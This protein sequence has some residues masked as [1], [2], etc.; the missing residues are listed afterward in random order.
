MKPRKLD[1]TLLSALAFVTV[2]T[3]CRNGDRYRIRSTQTESKTVEL[4]AAKSVQTELKMG[5]GDLKISG[6]SASLMNATFQYN[7]PGMEAGS[8]LRGRGHG[9]AARDRCNRARRTPIWAVFIIR[10]TYI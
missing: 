1:L 7:V 10:G 8:E 9:R 4:G 6:G 3:G 5:A 2:L